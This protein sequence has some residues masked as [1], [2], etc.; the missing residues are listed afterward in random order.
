MKPDATYRLQL[1]PTFGFAAAAAVA[2]Y[3]ALLGI[4][5]VYLSPVLQAA[6]GSTHGYDV[7]DHSHASDELGGEEGFRALVAACRA[8]GLGVIVDV[9]PNHMAAALPQNR[10][11]WDVLE[12]G[13]SSLWA[14]FFDIDWDPP[15]TSLRNRVLLPVL[16]TRYGRALG[17]IDVVYDGRSF[18]VRYFDNVFPVAPRSLDRLLEGAAQSVGSPELEFLA[19]AL[20]SLPRSSAT[21]RDSVR[22]RH[23]D[24]GVL[25]DRVGALYRAD[26]GLRAAIDSALISLNGDPLALDELLERQNYRLAYWRTA[27]QQLDYRRYFDIDTLVGLRVE[28]E[29]VFEETHAHVLHWAADGLVDGVRIDHIDGLAAPQ[30][31]LSRLA[32]RGVGWIVVEKILAPDETLPAEWPVAGTTGYEFG[33]TVTR[34]FVDPAGE[35]A[36]TALAGVREPAEEVVRAAKEQILATSLGADLNR[37]VER[38][39][40]LAEDDPA[41]R[42]VTRA[43]MQAAVQE[44]IVAFPVYRTYRGRP[45]AVLERAV[46]GMR[47]DVDPDVLAFV[48]AAL[49]QGGD[50]ARRFEQLTGPV[51][52][53]GVEDTA[54][55]R[56]PRLTALCEVGS[57]LGE[58]AVTPAEWHARCARTPM[59]SLLAT[60]THDT[61]RS[62][63]VRARLVLLSEIPARWS[64]AVA[65]WR[66]LTAR[67]RTDVLPD[68]PTE[69][70]LLQA[71]AGAWPI[72]VDRA[73]AYAQKATREAKVHTSWTRPVPA[74]EEAVERWVRGALGDCGFVASMDAF[75]ADLVEPGRVV[76]L[77]MTACKLTAPG[78][79][80]IYQGCELWDLSLVDPDN[81]R[82]VDFDLRARLLA[83]PDGH[84][85]QRLIASVLGLRRRRPFDGPY[86]PLAVEGGA[87]AHAVAFARGG[88]VVTVVPRL[89]LG[90]AARADGWAGTTVR[91]PPGR[92]RDVVTGVERDGG[93]EP[94]AVGAVLADFPVAVLERT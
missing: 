77:A 66:E 56:Y 53:K 52:A 68:Q 75:V 60:S 46:A 78:V 40:R 92:W 74:Y 47:G 80:D 2:P 49:E 15:E 44:L 41:M 84:P 51:M 25:L 58:W 6:P 28:D 50:A 73:L 87:A 29:E 23:R 86:T 31:Y 88:D 35:E 55:Y 69:Q 10:W 38:L 42:D 19:S 59:G 22:R 39:L 4:S 54:F 63:D 79:P 34:L 27:D 24:K 81:R 21:D 20:G 76:S 70:L 16:G 64:S 33:N 89:V 36:L 85:K 65:G 82:P 61:K 26:P 32:G 11:W 37:V 13:P 17:D 1:T 8:E 90:L 72:D 12:N 83:A 18:T 5:H 43:E 30:Q 91:L 48:L 3:L 9:V 14:S 93:P 7:V 67:H 71:L 94:A 57:E 45:A 62:E